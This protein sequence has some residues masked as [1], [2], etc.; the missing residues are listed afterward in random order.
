MRK[1]IIYAKIYKEYEDIFQVQD[2]KQGMDGCQKISIL[3]FRL[4]LCIIMKI[5]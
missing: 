2:E 4:K 3:F 1:Q 5:K